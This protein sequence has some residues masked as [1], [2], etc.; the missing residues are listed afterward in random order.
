MAES[1][2][3]PILVR[4]DT[5]VPTAVGVSDPSLTLVEFTDGIGFF[6]AEG[7]QHDSFTGLDSLESVALRKYSDHSWSGSEHER[8]VLCWDMERWE[9]FERFVGE[10]GVSTNPWVPAVFFLTEQEY[11]THR[12][13]LQAR[14]PEQVLR[15]AFESAAK[16][17]DLEAELSALRSGQRDALERLLVPSPSKVQPRKATIRISLP[18]KPA[19]KQAIRLELPSSPGVVPLAPTPAAASTLAALKKWLKDMVLKGKK[20]SHAAALEQLKS[21]LSKLSPEERTEIERWLRLQKPPEDPPTS[22]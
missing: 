1:P 17:K 14:R 21:E 10:L 20:P 2:T 18:P 9:E 19:G 7:F 13:S 8:V 4:D 12:E 16:V 11:H 5:I 15:A 6:L 22:N 3:Q